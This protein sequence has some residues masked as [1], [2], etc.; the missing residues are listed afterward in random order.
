MFKSESVEIFPINQHV[1]LG[2][3]ES[4]GNVVRIKSLRRETRDVKDHCVPG[5]KIYKSHHCYK[6]QKGY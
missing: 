2:R 5:A 1:S 4:S 6:N 3:G